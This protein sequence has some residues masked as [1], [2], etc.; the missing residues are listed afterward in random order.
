M[1]AK[2]R[3]VNSGQVV[4]LLCNSTSGKTEVHFRQQFM[5]EGVRN[6]RSQPV[7]S[8]VGTVVAFED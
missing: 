3:Y 1:I 6:W 2:H 5:P 7:Q 4:L 8:A